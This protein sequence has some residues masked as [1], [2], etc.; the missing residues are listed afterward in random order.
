[1]NFHTKEEMSF[2]LL[3]LK[4]IDLNE[5]KISHFN[6]CYNKSGDTG[7]SSD[8]DSAISQ[9]CEDFETQMMAHSSKYYYSVISNSNSGSNINGESVICRR[10]QMQ[11]GHEKSYKY[12]KNESMR[13]ILSSNDPLSCNKSSPRP[14]VE[15]VISRVDNI[16]T[17]EKQQ[18]NDSY[19]LPSPVSQHHYLSVFNDYVKSNIEYGDY[20]TPLV[21]YENGV[22]AACS[23]E[24]EVRN[25]ETQTGIMSAITQQLAAF[26]K[27]KEVKD[28]IQDKVISEKN[29]LQELQTTDNN[30]KETKAEDL[31]EEKKLTCWTCGKNFVKKSHLKRHVRFHLAEQTYSCLHCKRKFVD[32]L[33]L[34]QHICAHVKEKQYNCKICQKSFQRKSG[35]RTHQ[36]VHMAKLFKCTYCSKKF[37]SNI[38]LMSHMRL[39]SGPPSMFVQRVASCCTQQELLSNTHNLI[40]KHKHKFIKNVVY[41]F[42]FWLNCTSTSA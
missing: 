27:H 14:Q 18:L 40:N 23:V 16:V 42:I 13:I 24:V 29:I 20:F 12:P 4:G 3:S 36:I 25:V 8:T 35:L 33:V 21:K 6:L 2:A 31:K 26:R 7:N 39:H 22:D 30:E 11:N 17:S 38:K 19:V 34:Q 32:Y 15:A 28:V 1:M 41:I 5:I 9:N 37:V 10:N